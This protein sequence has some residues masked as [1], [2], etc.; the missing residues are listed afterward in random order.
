MWC[1]WTC[2]LHEKT[3]KT[4]K[5]SSKSN[6]NFSINWMQRSIFSNTVYKNRSSLVTSGFPSERP[7]HQQ[8]NNR[9]AV[10]FKDSNFSVHPHGTKTALC[11][12]NYCTQGDPEKKKKGEKKKKLCL[13]SWASTVLEIYYGLVAFPI[14][15]WQLP[16]AVL[17]SF[18]LQM[19]ERCPI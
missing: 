9:P 6:S 11:W 10:V 1:Q 12:F 7:T 15:K 13:S 17:F 3:E 18:V 5:T 14:S 19:W 4:K 8:S 16:H 2:N